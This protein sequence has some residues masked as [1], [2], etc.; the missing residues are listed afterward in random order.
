MHSQHLRE[1]QAKQRQRMG[2]ALIQITRGAAGGLDRPQGMRLG[3]VLEGCES[4]ARFHAHRPHIVFRQPNFA[5][6][7]CS[8]S[9]LAGQLE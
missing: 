2:T 5:L 1:S 9:A 3:A 8:I 6:P 4:N 7:V